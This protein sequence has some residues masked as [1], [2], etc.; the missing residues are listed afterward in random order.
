MGMFLLIWISGTIYLP[1]PYCWIFLSKK[2]NIFQ[3]FVT[4][5]LKKNYHPL[6]ECVA[7]A[8]PHSKGFTNGYRSN[9][10]YIFRLFR[11][12]VERTRLTFAP[13]AHSFTKPTFSLSQ[14]FSLSPFFH[15]DNFFTQST[16]SLSQLF[17]NR[18][19]GSTQIP[20]PLFTVFNWGVHPTI[21]VPKVLKCKINHYFWS[22]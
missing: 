6:D 3:S 14:I 20:L 13:S 2:Y 10:F 15:S 22:T 18:G 21:N 12:I 7:V 5:L 19:G 4:R 17:Q 16:F 11:R 8:P 1:S 9:G